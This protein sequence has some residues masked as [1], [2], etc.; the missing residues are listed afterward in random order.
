M[1]NKTKR[2]IRE[3]FVAGGKLSPRS[4]EKRLRNSGKLKNFFQLTL[5]GTTDNLP[6]LVTPEKVPI[7]PY[8]VNLHDAGNRCII[9]Y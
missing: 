8:G 1:W 6:K 5:G 2:T 9:R 7:S 4:L 3:Q